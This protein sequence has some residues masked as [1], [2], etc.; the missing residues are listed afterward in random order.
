M[1]ELSQGLLG[2]LMLSF[3]GWLTPAWLVAMAGA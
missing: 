3:D 2:V 1:D